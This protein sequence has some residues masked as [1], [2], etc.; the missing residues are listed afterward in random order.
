[1]DDQLEDFKKTFFEES[2]DLLGMAEMHLMDLSITEPSAESLGAIFRSVHSIK[3]GAGAFGFERLV[4]FTHSFESVLDALRSGKITIDKSR[5]DLL[6]KGFDVVSDLVR[7]AKGD[8][9]LPGDREAPVLAGLNDWYPQENAGAAPK[10]INVLETKKKQTYIVRFKPLR[11]LYAK[12]N[13]PL[14]ILRQIKNLGKAVIACTTGGVP[15]L[16]RM[17]P[18]EAYIGWIIQIET[19]IGE[20]A[21]MEVF[22]F[23]D[24]DSE[25]SI[26]LQPEGPQTLNHSPFESAPAAEHSASHVDPATKPTE[27][28]VPVTASTTHPEKAGGDKGGGDKGGGDKGSAAVTSIRVDLDKIDRLVNMVGEIVIT[29]AMVAE[30][31]SQL[32]IGNKSLLN[33]LESMQQHTRELQDSVM[34]IR[35]QPVK[36]VFQRMPR[37]VRELAGSLN[38]DVRLVTSGENTEVDKTVIEQLSD[39]LTHMIRNSV[40]HGIEMPDK[41]E[42]VGKPREGTIHLSAE[43]RSGR[44][45]IQIVDDGGGINR[46][47]V[48]QKCIEKGLINPDA[49]LT[50]EEIDN[51]IFLPGFSTAEKVSNVSGRGVGMDVVKKNIQALGGRVNVINKPGQGSRFVLSLPLTLAVLDGMVVTVG[52]ERYVLPLTSI[53]ELLRPTPEMISKLVTHGD[54]IHIRGEYIR[55]LYVH[56]IFNIQDAVTDPNNAL[57]VLVE[58]DGGQ[59]VGLVVD[60][61]IGQQ[62]V[63]IKSLESNYRQIEGVSA[64]TILGD[65]RV[66]LILDVIGLRQIMLDKSA[67]T[68]TLQT[69]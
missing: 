31:L 39:P 57:V 6:M 52:Q 40:D 2:T 35:A 11:T 12:A 17:D 10:A 21:L 62:Q 55:L 1:M 58:V 45:V 3:G 15:T 48:K 34:S 24:V 5:H 27:A 22:E 46:E 63:V 14:L 59:K 23:V 16:D 66:A 51:F 68:Q 8:V 37:L 28:K 42:S 60:E 43:H 7:E 4:K 32:N 9:Q 13:E 38:K 33:G 29:Q 56:Q 65:G 53:I 18:E 41:R 19:D 61:V 50:D 36:S 67:A 25:L 30:Q 44:I 47:R 49:Q 54:L 20:T 69:A 26:Q 64:A